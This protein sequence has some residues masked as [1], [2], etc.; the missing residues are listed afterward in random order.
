MGL[1]EP[2][3]NRA[4][5]QVNGTAIKLDPR[6]GQRLSPPQITCVS[7]NLRHGGVE[8]VIGEA[9]G[10]IAT[11]TRQVEGTVAG[12]ELQDVEGQLDQL[13]IPAVGARDLAAV[14]HPHVV[15]PPIRIAFDSPHLDAAAGK[16][17]GSGHPTR[18]MISAQPRVEHIAQAFAD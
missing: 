9:A 1:L 7:I 11:A 8:V 12:P 5:T 4:M 16:V 18:A 10:V 14:D 15:G 13:S 3:L 6:K 17:C 2:N